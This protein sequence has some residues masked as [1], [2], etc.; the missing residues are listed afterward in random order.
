MSQVKI[1][2]KAPRFRDIPQITLARYKVDIMWKYLQEWIDEHDTDMDPDYQR[3]Y[4]WSISQKERYI[5]WIIR[6]GQSGKD[7]YFNHPGWFKKWD[8]RMEVVDGKQRISAALEFLDNKVKAFG[9]YLNQYADK[10]DHLTCSFHVHVLDLEDRKELLQ[11]YIDMNDGGT[12]HTDEDINKVK[13]L[14]NE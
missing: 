11:W 8:G 12:V 4:I 1:R 6:G 5:E 13:S 14:L 9:Y 7:I 10:L 2:E 3:G